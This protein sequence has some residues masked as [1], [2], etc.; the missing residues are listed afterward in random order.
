MDDHEGP[1]TERYDEEPRGRKRHQSSQ[2]THLQSQDR[3]YG[4]AHR[5]LGPSTPKRGLLR[6]TSP[7][8]QSQPQSEGILQSARR[9]SLDFLTS[10][11]KARRG[12]E[13]QP[14]KYRYEDQHRMGLSRGRKTQKSRQVSRPSTPPAKTPRRPS[15]SKTHKSKPSVLPRRPSQATCPQTLRRSHQA[16]SRN[17]SAQEV[18]PVQTSAGDKRTGDRPHR[19]DLSD[20]D[21][22]LEISKMN[23]LLD[24]WDSTGNPNWEKETFA[25]CDLEHCGR[26][27]K[28]YVMMRTVRHSCRR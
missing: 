5:P 9:L 17:Y 6:A 14:E 1:P 7:G 13:N 16:Q 3:E 23:G 26:C 19:S 20:L 22:N 21:G 11:W 4:K 8:R 2:S 15:T 27:G 18:S 28:Y 12:E 24:I 10:P 25:V